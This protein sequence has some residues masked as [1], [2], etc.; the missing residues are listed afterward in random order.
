MQEDTFAQHIQ[1]EPTG[2]TPNA[3]KKVIIPQVS[4]HVGSVADPTVVFTQKAQDRIN[5]S[6]STPT[7]TGY[8]QP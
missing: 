7:A 2:D 1:R 5:I 3:I 8:A 4:G 6:K